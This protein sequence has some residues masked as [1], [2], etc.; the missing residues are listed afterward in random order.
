MQSPLRIIYTDTMTGEADHVDVIQG[1]FDLLGVVEAITRK[2]NE[3]KIEGADDIDWSF[4]LTP[5][6]WAIDQYG[7]TACFI[8]R[9]D[10]NL[11]HGVCYTRFDPNYQPSK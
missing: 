4:K 1:E 8:I 7:T 11:I 5:L 3:I 10:E 9:W 6:S 2:W